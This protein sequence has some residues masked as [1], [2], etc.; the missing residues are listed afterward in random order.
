MS[1]RSRRKRRNPLMAGFGAAL[2][3]GGQLIDKHYQNKMQELKEARLMKLEAQ[4]MSLQERQ[5]DAQIENNNALNVLAGRR[6]DTTVSEGALGRGAT[7]DLQDDAQEFQGSESALGRGHGLMMQE[8]QQGF[9]AGESALGREQQT[10]ERVGGEA[11]RTGDRQV[12]QGF[13]TSEREAG[14]THGLMTQANQNE[15]QSGENSLGRD[16]QVSEG[17]LDRESRETISENALELSREEQQQ[18]KDMAEGNRIDAAHKTF[19]AEGRAM[20]ESAYPAQK[21]LTEVEKLVFKTMYEHDMPAEE[22]WDML[23]GKIAERRGDNAAASM[24]PTKAQINK[25]DKIAMGLE[26]L[27]QETQG[28]TSYP[29]EYDMMKAFSMFPELYG[30][31]EFPEAP[32]MSTSNPQTSLSPTAMA[33]GYG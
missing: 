28:Q 10:S 15:W 13:T 3:A 16:T 1:K 22:A 26:T 23:A 12:A 27:W 20:V 32:D 33:G 6:I 25:I 2:T 30:A 7:A 5:I 19:Y 14:Q 21:D 4:K 8:N 31:I 11:W 18:R 9:M 29:V 17:A 24:T